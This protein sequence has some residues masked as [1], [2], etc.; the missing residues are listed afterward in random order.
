MEKKTPVP[1]TRQRFATEVGQPEKELNLARAALLVAQGEYPQL[2]VDP[3]LVR[4]DVM[5]EE[6]KDRLNG[7]TAPPVVLAELN[8]TLYERHRLKGNRDD[9]YD[10]KNSY[11]ND[12]LDRGL[13]IPLTLGIVF[14]ETGWRLGLPLEGVDFP[15]HFLVRQRG[16]TV[17]LLIDP[18]HHGLVRFEDQA[19]EVLDQ[20]Y[21]GMV[22]LQDSHLNRASKRDMLVR[23]LVNLKTIHQKTDD[24]KRTLAVVEMLLAVHPTSP[25]EIRDRGVLLARLGRADEAVLQLEAYLTFAPGAGDASKVEA[26]LREIQNGEGP[27][28]RYP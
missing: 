22:R 17:N 15:G 6:V 11:L 20:Q 4:L 2:P 14:L 9:Y 21:G 18:Y 28:F 19:Q 12:V 8:R 24:H 16:E 27:P 5:A 23:L 13:G 3:Y 25:G 7:E 26:L 10:A 1:S